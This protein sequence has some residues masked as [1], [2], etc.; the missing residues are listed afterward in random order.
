MTEAL[1][2]GRSRSAS[3]STPG[4]R[5]SPTRATS[6]PTCTAPPES[7]LPATAGRCSSRRRR[8]SSSSVELRDLGEHRLK[9]LSAPE[10]IYQL[11]DGDF[12]AAQVSV[13]HEPPV[14]ATP[15]LGREAE[16]AEVVE[17]LTEDGSRLLTLTG[18]GGTGKTRL[19][20]QAA[21]EASESFPD[22]VFW[23]PLAPLRDPELVLPSLAQTL[24]VS[25]ERG[26]PLAETLAAHL[27][28]KSLLVLLDNVEHLL[29]PAAERD[30]GAALVERVASARHEP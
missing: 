23:V 29:P 30:R 20:L 2:P 12:P 8:R 4:R 10:R 19:A 24:A 5:S 14:P 15:F 9:D 26:T 3:A 28:G 22:G 21:A 7:R 11:G 25:E 16:L 18:P 13:P 17:L 27:S 1:A 6:A